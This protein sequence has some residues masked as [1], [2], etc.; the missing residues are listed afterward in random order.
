VNL[1]LNYE[2]EIESIRIFDVNGKDVNF[3]RWSWTQEGGLVQVNLSN[4]TAGSYLM[5][6]TMT[7]GTYVFRMAKY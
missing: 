5:H 6:A 2:T 3:D 1:A 4:L 7:N